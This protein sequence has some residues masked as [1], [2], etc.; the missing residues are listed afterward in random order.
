[1]AKYATLKEEIWSHD[2]AI[3][4]PYKYSES[5]ESGLMIVIDGCNYAKFNFDFT[6]TDECRISKN[7][8]GGLLLK[9]KIETKDD[10]IEKAENSSDPLSY[11][12]DRLICISEALHMVVGEAN[13]HRMNYERL[14][15]AVLK[16]IS[17][18]DLPEKNLRQLFE[19]IE[20]SK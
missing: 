7:N 13:A 9:G 11:V 15:E 1:M 5:A 6:D 4:R 19:I 12:A 2:L 14:R 10:V 16:L 17:E 18:H 8:H 20:V 3:G